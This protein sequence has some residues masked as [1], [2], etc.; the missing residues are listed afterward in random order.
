MPGISASPDRQIH[1]S[2]HRHDGHVLHKKAKSC[3]LFLTK[4]GSGLLVAVLHQAGHLTRSFLPS[5]SSEP[6]SRSP[7]Q[8]SL[9]SPQVVCPSRHCEGCLLTVRALPVCH[10]IQPEMPSVLLP[11]GPWPGVSWRCVCY[12]GRSTCT[13]HFCQS[14]SFTRF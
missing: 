4:P 7:Q 10:S 1:F 13:M 14:H 12:H 5:W 6:A 3:A 11:Q 8:V 2:T 9:F